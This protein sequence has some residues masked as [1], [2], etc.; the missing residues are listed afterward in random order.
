MV[1]A[2]PPPLLQMRDIVKTFPGARALDGVDLDIR[3]GEVHCLLGQNGAGKST[4]I[5]ILA[6]AHQPDEGEI[7]W[8]GEPVT[9]S[10]PQAALAPR[11]RHDLPGARRRRRPDRRGEHLP[12]PRAG[13]PAGSC[14][15]PRRTRAPGTCCAGSATR[16]I[17]PVARW[18]GSR[19][20][21]SR[22]CRWPG[23]C[24]TTPGSSSWTSRPRCSTPRRWRTSSGWSARSPPRASPSSTSPTAWRRSARSATGS[25]CSRTAAPSPPTCRSPAPRPRELIRLMTGRTVDVGP[26]RAQ[27]RDVQGEPVLEVDGPRPRR[28]LRRRLV[29][30]ARRGDRRPRRPRRRRPL[31]DP[32]DRLRR[33]PPPPPARCG[34]TARSCAPGS[35][36]AA[37]ARGVGLAPE[38]RKS[39]GLLLDEPV[40]RNITLSTFARFARSGFLDERAERARGRGSRSRRCTCAPADP[41]RAIRTLSGGNQQKAMLARWL[42]HGCS[43][44]LL[45]EPTR[46]VDVGARAEIYAPHPRAR[47]RGCR[48]RRRL[49]RDRGGPGA[50]RPGPRRRR[51]PRRPPGPGRPHRRARRARPRHGRNS[52]MSETRRPPRE[53]RGGAAAVRP[54]RRCRPPA[55]E[56]QA[57]CRPAGAAWASGRNLGLV[58]ALAAAVRRRRRHRRRA[59]RQRRQRHDDPAAGRRHRRRERRHDLRHHRRRH[60][61]VG[62]L[63]PRPGHGVG[64]DAGH[65]DDGRRTPTGSSW[66]SPRSPWAPSPG[67][68]TG[69]SSPT[70]RSWPSSP[71]WR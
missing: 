17:P 47:R 10:G 67:W 54:A 21:A 7:R 29:H 68:S 35:V 71:R 31:R 36:P 18:A 46:G 8:L 33:P 70:A 13:P 4:L 56:T 53:P 59:V 60:R 32:R 55:A 20:P 57:A 30:G 3:A 61:P 14:A 42:V 9:I 48:R 63:G 69:C 44:L 49:Q 40:Y 26:R 58:I 34:C 62:R 50:R 15:G 25:P 1:T 41:E 27:R 37:V 19:P 5:K 24:R 28:R 39:Q 16:E 6:G 64:D 65:P 12:R 66:S 45:D 22:S 38:E 43:V 23:R 51:R 2:D 11:R 52:R